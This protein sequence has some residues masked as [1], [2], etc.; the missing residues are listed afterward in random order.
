MHGSFNR[1]IYTGCLSFGHATAWFNGADYAGSGP[2]IAD[3]NFNDFTDLDATPSVSNGVL[4][5]PDYTVNTTITNFDEGTPGQVIRLLKTGGAG[6]V[7]IAHGANIYTNTGANKDL[8][9]SIV[10]TYTK[11]NGVW[12]ESE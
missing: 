4:F 7:T 6:T 3:Q 2:L 5:K 11:I 9:N 1:N 12:Y 10:Y 8:V